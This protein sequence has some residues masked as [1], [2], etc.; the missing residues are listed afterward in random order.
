MNLEQRIR[1]IFRESWYLKNNPDVLNDGVDAWEHFWRFGI[2]E[3]RSPNPLFDLNHLPGSYRTLVEKANIKDY[4][5]HL[6]RQ[7]PPIAL[8][9]IEWY[10]SQTKV[11]LRQQSVFEHYLLIGADQGFEPCPLFVSS[12]F[13]S[14]DD[15]LTPLETYL[16]DRHRWNDSIGPYFSGDRYLTQNADVQEA[17][18]NPLLH[19]FDSGQVADRFSNSLFE[20][21]FVGKYLPEANTYSDVVA[22]L[23]SQ[24]AITPAQITPDPL[25]RQLLEHALASDE[26]LKATW[27]TIA[28]NAH[29][30][31]DPF[32]QYLSRRARDI[33]LP[34]VEDPKVSVIVPTFNDAQMTLSCLEALAESSIVDSCQ[35]IVV[36]DGSDPAITFPLTEVKNL[37]MV[38]LKKNSGYSAAVTVGVE[39]A[40][41]EYIFLH[42]NDAQVLPTTLEVLANQLADPSIGG[43]GCLVL[44]SN[45][46]IQE[47]GCGL[48]KS[49]FATQYGNGESMSNPFFRYS[50][51]VDY[52][53][54]VALMLRR[55]EWD[56]VGGYSEEYSPAYYED[57][58][59]SCKISEQGMRIRYCASALVLHSEGS[60]HGYG[61]HGGKAFQFRNRRKFAKKWS[62]RLLNC[63]DASD[64]YKSP[65]THVTSHSRSQREVIIVDSMIPDPTVDSGSVRMSE[66]VLELNQANNQIQFVGEN[67]NDRS[68]WSWQTSLDGIC[69]HQGPQSLNDALE[70]TRSE[71]PLIII[72]RPDVYARAI[73][74]VLE[75]RPR[76]WVAYDSVDS[77]E[78]RL[79]QE[80]DFESNGEDSNGTSITDRLARDTRTERMAV[81]SADCVISV[82]QTDTSHFKSYA[83]DQTF[84]EISNI[85]RVQPPPAREGRRD[86][87][88]VGGYRHTPNVSAAL[89]AAHEVMPLVWRSQPASRLILAGSFPP[90]ELR[91]LRSE[92]ILVPGWLED[93]SSV[94]QTAAVSIAPL[95]FGAGVKGKVGEA[96]ALGI[97]VVATPIAVDGMHTSDGL[98]VLVADSGEEFAEAV[99]KL[100]FDEELW[101]QVSEGGRALIEEHFSPRQAKSE[102]QRLI[103]SYD[104]YRSSSERLQR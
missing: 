82:S 65:R 15:S 51:D 73:S 81:H 62:Q 96:M 10:L 33:T 68:L 52:C 57:A 1:A 87:V 24:R 67:S 34:V 44:D 30:G 5:L 58:D 54:A 18:V 48:L 17:Q 55:T 12:A 74:K 101:Q 59:L 97:P 79:L 63:P 104:A 41:G 32:D 22:A 69:W 26:H 20:G 19:F 83:P 85:H 92:R 9:D 66:I 88:F 6:H 80:R 56:G 13:R 43:I 11:N 77:H 47:A 78:L 84:F 25:A 71:E 93:L 98:N 49:G 39:A 95:Q 100:M 102:I 89:F 36:D 42:N 29:E 27:R 8:F 64:F 60:S 99:V 31:S 72:S 70:I 16:A 37:T 14:E 94:Y 76:A 21:K 2:Q 7:V 40:L 28:D 61:L 50:R 75:H 53:S 35:I 23:R 86:V 91:S 4:L 46:R 45:Y 3:G 103:D 38:K 90:E